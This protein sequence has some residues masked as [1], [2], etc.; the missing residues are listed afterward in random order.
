M[1]RLNIKWQNKDSV[2]PAAVV[3]G[4]TA[5]ESAKASMAERPMLVFITSD[6]ETDKT[7][8]KLQDV[9][10]ANESFA[11]GTKLFDCIKVSSGNALQNRFIQEHGS[12]T[13]RMLLVSRDYSKV[14]SLQGKQLSAGKLLK[15]MKSLARSEYKNS[16]DKMVRGYVKLLNG[17]DRLEGRKAKLADDDARLQAKPNASKAK[18]IARD[19]AELE[20]DIEAWE[21]SERKLLEFKPKEVKVKA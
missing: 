1:A 12:Q 13:P 15:A 18:K 5:D 19:R 20:K 9:V 2:G 17:L 16:F 3:T 6:D 11:I 7:M 14:Q 21:A 8:R 10:F 4:K